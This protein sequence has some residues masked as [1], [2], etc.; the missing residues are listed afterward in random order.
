LLSIEGNIV[1]QTMS[2]SDSPRASKK[3]WA[4]RDT[5]P[6]ESEAMPEKKELRV[7]LLGKTGSGKSSLGNTL[8]GEKKFEVSSRLISATER[9]SWGQ[10][11]RGEWTVKVTDTPGMCDTPAG[12]TRDLT[13]EI[14]KSLLVVA[15]GPHVV[16][17]LMRCDTPLTEGEMF[18]Y[19]ALKRMFGQG[20]CNHMILVLVGVDAFEGDTLEQRQNAARQFVDSPDCP[21]DLRQILVDVAGRFYFVDNTAST[22]LKEKQVNELLVMMQ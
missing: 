18:A 20:I 15:P 5:S 13:L 19:K 8:L 6:K 9:C 3:K 2:G 11:K 1:P 10:V 17:M 16:L 22:E 21:E 4:R 14:L 7:L 12:Q